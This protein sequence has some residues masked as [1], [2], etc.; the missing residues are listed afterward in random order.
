MP[1]YEY[2]CSECTQKFD[3]YMTLAEKESGKKPECPNCK[4]SNVVQVL[5]N[6]MIMG[7]RSSGSNLPPVCGPNAEP[8]CCK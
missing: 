8:S 5:G 6:I 4:G 7:S 2:V 3:V 1:T